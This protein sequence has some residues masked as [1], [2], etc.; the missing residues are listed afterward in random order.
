M[1]R[2]CA[3]KHTGPAFHTVFHV[4]WSLV[5]A[6]PADNADSS[7][8]LFHPQSDRAIHRVYRKRGCDSEL[9]TGASSTIRQIAVLGIQDLFEATANEHVIP[10]S[11]SSK[12]TPSVLN[13]PHSRATEEVLGSGHQGSVTERLT[14]DELDLP[15]SHSE[16]IPFRGG[17]FTLPIFWDQSMR[18]A[19]GSGM[20][21]RGSNEYGV[22]WPVGH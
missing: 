22:A 13:M 15:D 3:T 6:F 2:S 21:P 19:T 14:D 12:L 20:G 17:E 11:L 5:V 9:A 10:P 7:A 18:L 16:R 8:R 1:R 4:L